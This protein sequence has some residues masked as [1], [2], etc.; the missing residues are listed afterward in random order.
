MHA[1]I[2]DRHACRKSLS[3]QRPSRIRQQDLTAVTSG[4]DPSG[5]VDVGPDV[6]VAAQSAVPGVQS[7]PDADLRPIRPRIG[8][9]TS[10]CLNRS[11]DG[12]RSGAEDREEGIALGADLD[13]TARSE[14]VTNQLVVRHEDRVESVGELVREPRRAFDVGEQKRDGARR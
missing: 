3:D 11:R 4:R 6:V 1:E 2:A 7:H 14:D 12:W 13:A 5:T 9:K 8:S 10:L